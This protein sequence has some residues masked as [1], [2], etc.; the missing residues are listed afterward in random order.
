MEGNFVSF[1]NEKKLPFYFVVYVCLI[2]MHIWSFTLIPEGVF[3]VFELATI[4]IL[5]FITF[6]ERNK[7]A[8]LELPYWKNIK[9]FLFISFVLGSVGAFVFHYQGFHYSIWRQRTA[10]FWLLYPVLHLFKVSPKK[11]IKM[12]LVLGFVWCILN[13]VQQFTYP[14]YLFAS[15]TEEGPDSEELLRAGV[16]RFMPN[17]FQYGLFLGFYSYQ[18]FLEKKKLIYVLALLLT[19]LGF[20]YYGTRQ[21]IAGLGACLIIFTFLQKGKNRIFG[22][23]LF[24]IIVYVVYSYQD[25]ILGNFIELTNNQVQD[26]DYIRIVAANFFLFEYWPHWSA[27]FTGNGL[28]YIDSA[29]GKETAYIHEVYSFFATDVGI[30][31]SFNSYGIFYVINIFVVLIKMLRTKFK[32]PSNNYLKLFSINA[33][34]LIILTDYFMSS[35]VIPFWCIIMYLIDRDQL[36]VVKK[37]PQIIANEN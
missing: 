24:T 31:G 30:I 8:S 13:I 27:I 11:L 36:S 20:Y 29:F 28:A 12:M 4:I 9:Y 34:L 18:K 7:I 14:K 2:T 5:I 16:Y 32:N 15:R 33:L 23:V 19:L 21:F 3:N 22:I 6:H 37:R 1:R 25:L 17:I 26:D 10:L 35:T